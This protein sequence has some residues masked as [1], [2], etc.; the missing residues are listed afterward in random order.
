MSGIAR[1]APCPCGSGRKYKKCCLEKHEM[2]IR[3]PARSLDELDGLSNRAND[4]IREGRWAEAEEV[5]RQLEERYPEQVDAEERRGQLHET[6]GD[7]LEALLWARRTLY[8]ARASA[9]LYDEE[10]LTEYDEWVADLTAKTSSS[11]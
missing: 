6:K 10:L 8:K 9:A 11:S 3:N 1:N 7:Y 2:A 5:C 4:L